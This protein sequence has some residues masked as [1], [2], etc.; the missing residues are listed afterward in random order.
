MARSQLID[1]RRFILPRRFCGLSSILMQ[2]YRYVNITLSGGLRLRNYYLADIR[3]ILN[4][5]RGLP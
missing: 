2:V 1:T 5:F 3:E 4:L